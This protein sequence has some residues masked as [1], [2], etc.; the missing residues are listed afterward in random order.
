MVNYNS[1]NIFKEILDIFDVKSVIKLEELIKLSLSKID[2]NLVS[3]ELDEITYKM[4]GGVTKQINKYLEE[5][6]QK[7]IPPIFT[8]SV[9]YPGRLIGRCHILKDDK[10]E[11]IQLKKIW[12]EFNKIKSC[13]KEID[14]NQFEILSCLILDI[15]GCEEIK[16]T[17]RKRD[18][19][20]DFFGYLPFQEPIEKIKI[21]GGATRSNVGDPKIREFFRSITMVEMKSR[22]LRT[23]LPEPF[24]EADLFVLGYFFTADKYS[25]VV[26]T[27]KYEDR[28]KLYRYNGDQMTSIICK[29]GICI[30]DD[31]QFD[32]DDFIEYLNKL[33]E[34]YPLPSR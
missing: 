11:I 33:D 2:K 14:E 19:A 12:L 23:I 15:K 22:E 13:L 24:L 18:K 9:S 31:F 26:E 7:K 32:Y 20:I 27:A 1:I 34:A 10:A 4:K 16:R 21:I 28:Y 3:I 8:W 6:N 17:V 30:D 5:N 29:K 25:D